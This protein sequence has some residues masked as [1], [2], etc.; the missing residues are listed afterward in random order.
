MNAPEEGK[1]ISASEHAAS[2]NWRIAVILPAFNEELT[3]RE[4]ILGFHRAVP[5]A[6]I[7]VINNN[8]SDRTAA[9]SRETLHALGVR[10]AVIEE[11]RQGKGN[12]LRRAFQDIEAD[13]YLLADADMTYPSEQALELLTPVREGRADMVVGDRFAHGQY[14]SKITRPFHKL[15]NRLFQWTVNALFSSRLADVMS[16]YR[17]FSR[18]FIKSYPVLVEGFQVEMDMTLHALH[19]RLKILE[20]PVAYNDRPR[21]SSSKLRTFSDGTKVLFAIF[22]ILRYYRPLFFFSILSGLFAACGLLAAMPVF[23]DWI[24]FRFIFHV[25][26][27]ILAAALEMAAIF[28]FGIGLI[29][30]SMA[31]HQRV[32]FE[33][34]RL[35]QG[36]RFPGQGEH[37][38]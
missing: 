10:G 28:L 18:R 7:Y 37:G 16:G 14:A 11:P 9:I 8:S 4:T 36:Q 15:G 22:R 34:R 23:R 30:D 21:G 24:E 12:A 26:L 6:S 3:V 35:A 2:P 25:P 1:M 31:Y 38:E 27:A 13:I 19:H 20:V 32:A 33:L 17:A 5:Q 29:L